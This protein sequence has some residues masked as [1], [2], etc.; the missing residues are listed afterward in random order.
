MRTLGVHFQR[1]EQCPLFSKCS[2]TIDTVIRPDN[3]CSENVHNLTSEQ[4]AA[5][6]VEIIDIASISRDYWSKVIGAPNVDLTTFKSQRTER[7]P[8]LKGWMVWSNTDFS[9]SIYANA[10]WTML[11]FRSLVLLLSSD[12]SRYHIYACT[13]AVLSAGFMR[14][15]D[16]HIQAGD[17]GC[18]HMGPRRTARRLHHCGGEGAVPGMPPAVL[19]VDRRMVRHD[20]GADPRDGAADRHAAQ[21]DAEKARE[22]RE[23]ARRQ[24]EDAQRRG[25]GRGEVHV[26]LDC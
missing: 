10:Q 16:D 8:L 1:A 20:H 18:S 11:P 24:Q 21:E 4:L 22:G 13:Y 12:I 15:G 3:G 26:V 17:H 19:R 23:Q 7:G 25:S 6:E 14:S 2:L 5:R 9:I